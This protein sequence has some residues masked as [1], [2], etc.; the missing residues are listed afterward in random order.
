MIILGLWAGVYLVSLGMAYAAHDRTDRTMAE[1]EKHFG[2]PLSLE[3]LNAAYCQNRPVDEAFWQQIKSCIEQSYPSDK[4]SGMDEMM[5]SGTPEGIYPESVFRQFKSVFRQSEPRT[6]IERMLNRRL[7]ARK[8][9]ILRGDITCLDLSE[10]NW[11]R[12]ISRWEL[13]NIRFAL[14]DGKTADACAAMDRMKRITDYLGNRTNS[15]L[16]TLVLIACERYRMLGYERLLAS[17][18]VPDEVLNRSRQ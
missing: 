6:K 12:D 9:R 14:A 5:L 1:L 3:A 4:K 17:G 7:P 13:W 8:L 11:C 15:L 10:L 18:Q 2:Q 16:T